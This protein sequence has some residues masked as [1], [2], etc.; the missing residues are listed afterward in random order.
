MLHL[1]KLAVGVRDI[2]HLRTLQAERLDT[3]PPLRHRTRN[4]PRRR[5]EIL[6]GGSM[7][8]VVSGTMLVR[9]RIVDIIEDHWDD[10]A[11]CTG[12]I[13]DPELVPLVGRPTKPFQGWRYLSAADAPEDMP[14]LAPAL[15]EAALPPAMQRELRALCLL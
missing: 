6:Q 2:D 12:L 13:L 9:Q 11:A 8:W 4:F 15:G 10:G 5:A 3:N 14:L 7:Y 1:T